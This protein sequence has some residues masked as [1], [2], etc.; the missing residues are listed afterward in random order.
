MFREAVNKYKNQ[1]ISDLAQQFSDP[2]LRQALQ[3][4]RKVTPGHGRR[5][6]RRSSSC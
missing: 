5:A 3:W 6:S 2:F 4:S 1:A